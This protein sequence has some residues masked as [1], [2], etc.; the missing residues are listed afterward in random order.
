MKRSFSESNREF[1]YSDSEKDDLL[2]CG[3]LYTKLNLFAIYQSFKL[4]DVYCK[5][6]L[7]LFSKN[8]VK[9]RIAKYTKKVNEK[10]DLKNPLEIVEYYKLIINVKTCDYN[11]IILLNDDTFAMALYHCNLPED[12]Q[13]NL[14]LFVM[15]DFMQYLKDHNDKSFYN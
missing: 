15:D 9:R 10:I 12:Q 7:D 1:Y 11:V 8:P 3:T 5:I 6:T 2:L 14:L 13:Q 4:N